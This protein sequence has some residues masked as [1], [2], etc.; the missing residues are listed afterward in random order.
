MN[1]PNCG[2]AIIEEAA[3]CPWCDQPVPGAPSY[4]DYVYEAFISYRH[5]PHDHEVAVRLQR[6]IEGFRIPKALRTDPD[7]KRLG[8]LFR[9]EDELPIA[10]S[11]PDQI[12]EALRRSRTLI[13]ICSRQTRA[14]QW[15]QREVELYASYHGRSRIRIALVEG[16]PDESFP[17]LLMTKTVVADDGTST[18]VE[19]EPLAADF[20]DLSRKHFDTERLRLVASIIGC[21]YDDLRQRMR[22]RRQRVALA[23]ASA[24]SA[25]S[26]SF[27]SSLGRN[28][29]LTSPNWP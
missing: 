17:P 5:L 28:L 12:G 20:R 27:G 8:K 21:G 15:V 29:I 24:V 19:E 11:L 3:F 23:V 26:V 18:L 25:L 2:H 4:D 13:V 9:D 10:S 7:R 6:A 1:C 14:S 16:E 22:A